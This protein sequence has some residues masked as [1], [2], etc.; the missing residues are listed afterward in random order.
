MK[1]LIILLLIIIL[2]FI[3]YDFYKDWE[4]FHA[5]NYHYTTDVTIDNDYHDQTVVLDY[6]KAITDLNTFVKLKWTASDID[7]RAPESDDLETSQAVQ[8]YGTKLAR[9]SCLEKKLA[10][11]AAYKKQGWNN[12]QILDFENNRSTPAMITKNRKIDLLHQL[13]NQ[14]VTASQR[15]GSRS[16]LIFEIQ[17][18]LIDKGYDIP[19]DGVFAQITS[20]A[21]ADFETKNNFYPDGKI[22][23]LTFDALIK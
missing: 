22:D 8:E 23:A 19:L 2:G 21:L 14:E 1:Q 17:K 11:S 12:Q 15:I 7:V 9:V 20:T 6:N 5:P 3:G 4:R 18:L 10:Q 13:F 16:A